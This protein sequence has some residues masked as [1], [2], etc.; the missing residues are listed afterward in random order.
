MMELFG[1]YTSPYVRHCRVVMM[2]LGQP[3][4]LIE[5]NNDLSA[6]GSPTKRVPYL[7]D[8]GRLLTDSSSILQYARQKAGQP[9]L[10]DLDDAERYHL[11]N[12]GLEATVN[13][14]QMEKDDIRPA[15]S[16]YLQRQAARAASVLELLNRDELAIASPAS[17]GVLR[18]AC[19]LG[20]ALFRKRIDIAPYPK[21]V[22]FF[23][24]AQRIAHF[25]ETA[26]PA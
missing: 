21:L 14:F 20:W 9:F 3:F 12:T 4:T 5:T 17:D 25:R 1:S 18:V 11:A 23:E 16:P 13:I 26:P 8:G 15:Q 7:R 22:S 2:Q 24:H 10:A 6:T 19:F